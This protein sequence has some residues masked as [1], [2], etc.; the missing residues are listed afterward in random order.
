[1]T[2][3][4]QFQHPPQ[5]GTDTAPSGTTQGQAQE[6]AE[7][8]K[9]EA[10]SV[11]QDAKHE[12]QQVAQTAKQEA[13]HVADTA[14]THAKRLMD[15][16]KTEL[17]GHASGQQ[18]RLAGEIR[19][20][21]DELHKMVR[22][23]D[24]SGPVHAFAG[25]AASKAGEVAQWLEQREPGDVLNEV[26]RF[27]ARKPGVFL[28]IAAGA[29]LLA[30]RLTRGLTADEPGSGGAGAGAALEPDNMGAAYI[31]GYGV[32][33]PATP[34]ASDP[35]VTEYVPPAGVETGPAGY[36]T[37]TTEYENLPA[38]PMSQQPGSGQWSATGAGPDPL[39][40]PVLD[41]EGPYGDRGPR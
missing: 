18:Q 21:A 34:L 2:Q 41:P 8:T 33:A 32:G 15:Q 1:M 26:R 25:Q 9:Q 23:N 38:H 35:E 12:G 19:N 14:G 11:A 29:G 28:A 30:G 17:D 37:G 4:S 7:H 10:A 27:A 13:K 40:E 5:G 16:A 31:P 20:L 6:V 22:S 3:G 24:G 36:A 39:V